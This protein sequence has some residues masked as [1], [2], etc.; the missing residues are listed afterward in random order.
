MIWFIIGVMA[1]VWGG[2]A[3]LFWNVVYIVALFAI[4]AIYVMVFVR[5]D[6]GI[7]KE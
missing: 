1:I 2:W 7:K 3:G 5:D 4:I 6:K